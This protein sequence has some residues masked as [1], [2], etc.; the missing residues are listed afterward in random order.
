MKELAGPLSQID[1]WEC[2]ASNEM[3]PDV[4]P[5]VGEFHKLFTQIDIL[6][7]ILSKSAPETL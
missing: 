6:Q 5:K 2:S 7:K 1:T 3:Y 4:D